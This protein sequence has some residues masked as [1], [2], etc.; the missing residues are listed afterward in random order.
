[1][2]IVI[3]RLHWEHLVKNNIKYQEW[4]HWEWKLVICQSSWFI[5]VWSIRIMDLTLYMSA[6]LM[7]LFCVVLVFLGWGER[8]GDAKCSFGG[9]WPFY[10]SNV[11]VLFIRLWSPY[12][13]Y[14]GRRWHSYYEWLVL[15]PPLMASSEILGGP[16]LAGL[17][18]RHVVWIFYFLVMFVY[19]YFHID[20]R[21]IPWTNIRFKKSLSH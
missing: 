15:E 7:V 8:V 11:L 20:C 13:L 9:V 16:T 4:E 17:R 10:I 1:M 3:W 6:N 18:R 2:S 12:M 21:A 5:Q 19:Y 14:S